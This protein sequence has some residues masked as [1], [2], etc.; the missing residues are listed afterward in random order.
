MLTRKAKEKAAI[1]HRRLKEDQWILLKFQKARLL[2][3]L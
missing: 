1:K 2:H 3:V